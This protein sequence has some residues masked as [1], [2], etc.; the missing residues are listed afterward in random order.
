MYVENVGNRPF[1]YAPIF[2]S[3]K[4]KIHLKKYDNL[5]ATDNKIEKLKMKTEEEVGWLIFF[6]YKNRP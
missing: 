1:A 6:H 5:H 3:R 2:S 4:E